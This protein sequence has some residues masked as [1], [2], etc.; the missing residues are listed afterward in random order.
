LYK[1]IKDFVLIKILLEIFMKKLKRFFFF[2][3]PAFFLFFATGCYDVEII[4]AVQGL[5]DAENSLVSSTG[6][7]FITCTNGVYEIEKVSGFGESAIYK[8][9]KIIDDSGNFLG[10]AEFNGIIYI[11][12]MKSLTESNLIAYNPATG[13]SYRVYRFSKVLMP[14]GI[15]FDSEGNL[16]VADQI[17]ISFKLGRIIKLEIDHSSGSVVNEYVWLD[18]GLTSPNG[19]LYDCGNLYITDLCK[20]K[21]IPIIKGNPG[22]IKE[23]YCRPLHVFDDLMKK[24]DN[25]IVCDFTKGTV[26]E[27]SISSGKVLRELDGGSIAG[28]SSVFSG[29][30][31]SVFDDDAIVVTSKGILY[32]LYSNIGNR[33][34][35]FYP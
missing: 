29:E 15:A 13:K 31:T 14:N 20:I 26:F 30:G 10:I 34:V 11:A 5:P 16:Y 33:L 19:M 18:Y 22:K 23:L 35:F 21:M 9:T 7:V 28:P 17:E 27:F 25:L 8:K 3:L 1:I 4:T 24:G 32:D 2:V 6:G 12:Q